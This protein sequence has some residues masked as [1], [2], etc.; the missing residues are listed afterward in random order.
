LDPILFSTCF[1]IDRH[2]P[3]GLDGGGSRGRGKSTIHLQIVINDVT[4][5]ENCTNIIKAWKVGGMRE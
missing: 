1:S 2:I 3:V 4:F 5:V